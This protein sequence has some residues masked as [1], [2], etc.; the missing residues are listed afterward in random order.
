LKAM[1]KY[2]I[3]RVLWE[4]SFRRQCLRHL[5]DRGDGDQKVEAEE[6]GGMND[7]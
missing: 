4:I 7:E 1:V 3:K 2:S 5:L 6:H